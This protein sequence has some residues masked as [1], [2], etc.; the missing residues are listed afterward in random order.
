MHAALQIVAR[1]AQIQRGAPYDLYLSAD[2]A[3]P[4]ALAKA[5]FAAS[6]VRPYAV[7]RIVLRGRMIDAPQTSP[8]ATRLPE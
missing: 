6:E 8:A 3:F 1:G 4:R 5:G 2:I 7:G